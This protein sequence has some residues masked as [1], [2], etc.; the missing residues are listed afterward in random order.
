M[1]RCS[2]CN[3][4]THTMFSDVEPVLA[5]N[6]HMTEW[7]ICPPCGAQVYANMPAGL[8]A[9][10]IARYIPAPAV[11]EANDQWA[12]RLMWARFDYGEPNA[13][14]ANCTS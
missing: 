9:T 2:Y 12:K 6:L 3:T 11:D 4:L 10:Y 5:S 14:T 7:H 1:E 8:S 13:L